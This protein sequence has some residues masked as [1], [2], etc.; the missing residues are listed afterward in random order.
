[1]DEGGKKAGLS[2]LS[3]AIAHGEKEKPLKRSR[4]KGSYGGERGI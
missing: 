2:F 1:M 3:S 4:F